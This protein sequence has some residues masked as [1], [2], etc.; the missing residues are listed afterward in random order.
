[1]RLPKIYGVALPVT[2]L[3]ILAPLFM[4]GVFNDVS[5]ETDETVYYFLTDHLGSVDVVMDDQGKIVERADYMPFGSDRLR[6]TS[7]DT[8]D[9][10]YKFTGK[11][12][13]DETGLMYYEARYYDPA[14]GRFITLDPLLLDEGSKPLAS[15]LSNPQSL[16][17]Y[18]Y[19]T[20][21]PVRYTDET[22]EYES[23][24]HYDLTYFLGIQSGLNFDDSFGIALADQKTDE[25]ASTNPY[26][27]KESRE[28]YHFPSSDQLNSL[29]EKASN[30]LENK[31]I[32]QYLH[33]LQDSFSH[34]GFGATIGHIYFGEL[35]D[36]TY[37]DVKR[38]D[39]MAKQTFYKLRIF[40]AQKNGTGSLD[41]KEYWEESH[42]IWSDIKDKIH[43]FNK[44]V[45]YQEKIRSL[46]PDLYQDGEEDQEK[47]DKE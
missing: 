18:S 33:A 3:L 6:I 13:D 10:D 30:S 1:M 43:N 22:G 7:A 34:A 47:S 46:Y 25:D 4:K 15:V 38:A 40:N 35:P 24:V 29:C 31:D 39:T 42:K 27:S 14:I 36:L 37:L 12:M 9:I 19:V 5:A 23:D 41:I 21:N 8:T 26:S 44:S 17:P 32:G 45:G 11:E 28:T 16:N 2:I 20:N